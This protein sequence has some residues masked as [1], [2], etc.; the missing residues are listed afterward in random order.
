LFLHY[1]ETFM[2]FIKPAYKH[3]FK[4]RQNSIDNFVLNPIST[5]IQVFN[6]LIGTAQ[7]TEFGKKY[8]FE[9]INDIKQ[10]KEIVPVHEYDDLKPY[11][12]K[13]LEGHQNILW[14][15]TISWFAKSSGTTS[16][17]SKFI[18]ISQQCLEDTHYKSGK[19]TL[20]LYFNIYPES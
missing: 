4:I 6:D 20:A 3:Y 9:H 7:Y 19:D 15:D 11:I 13:I 18:P 2:S 5:Q 10:F 14:P 17:K 8:N 1:I 16:D 12:Q